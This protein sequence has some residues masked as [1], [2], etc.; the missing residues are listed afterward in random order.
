M[1]K[2]DSTGVGLSYHT[3]AQQEQTMSAKHSLRNI[4]LSLSTVTLVA[5]CATSSPPKESGFMPDYSRLQQVSTPDG[6][7]RL[8]YVSPAFTPVKYSAIKLDPV[9]YY[10]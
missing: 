2:N 8:V 10:P 5:G 4:F 1:N 7:A 6:G 3:Q 9:V